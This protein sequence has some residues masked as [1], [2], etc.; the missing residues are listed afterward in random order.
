MKITQGQRTKITW[1]EKNHINLAKSRSPMIWA[2]ARH[3]RDK[4]T[5]S[6]KKRHKGAQHRS[7]SN[8]KLKW[9]KFTSPPWPHALEPRSIQS[10]PKT[11][12]IEQR[13]HTSSQAPPEQIRRAISKQSRKAPPRHMHSPWKHATSKCMKECKRMNAPPQ[14]H[15]TSSYARTTL[16]TMHE[17]NLA[18]KCK[19]MSRYTQSTQ[20][21]QI[22]HKH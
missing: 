10:S 18:W 20:A 9:T 1:H 2:T 17:P 15:K 14:M 11:H 3:N 16:L 19:S 7:C 13:A 4:N 12:V 22:G 8:R 5:W 21:S 6:L